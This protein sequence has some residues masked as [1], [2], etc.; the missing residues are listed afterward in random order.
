MNKRKNPESEITNNKLK[1][2]KNANE[3]Q[4]KSAWVE[5]NQ[6]AIRQTIINTKVPLHGNLR[7]EVEYEEV[8]RVLGVDVNSMSFWLKDNYKAKLLKYIL[9]KYGV[10]IAGLQEVCINWSNFKSSQTLAS[11]LRVK[12]K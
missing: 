12:V 7:V 10:D 2:I 1:E 5:E 9:E 6:T 11:I 4:Q 8:V 3:D